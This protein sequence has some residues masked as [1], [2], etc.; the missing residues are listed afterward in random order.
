MRHLASKQRLQLPIDHRSPI[1]YIF[2]AWRGL[3]LLTRARG[4]FDEHQEF[5]GRT[6][7]LRYSRSSECR[8]SGLAFQLLFLLPTRLQLRASVLV[9]AP[10]FL[11]PRLLVS[12]GTMSAARVPNADIAANHAAKPD[13]CSPAANPRSRQSASWSRRLVHDFAI[14]QNGQ[15]GAD[16]FDYAYHSN[17]VPRLDQVTEIIG[18][19]LRLHPIAQP[20]L[21]IR[22]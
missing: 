16:G 3:T 14:A 5:G 10:L 11:R 1:Q 2:P 12:S 13:Q 15:A 21:F 20:G 6:G 17:L 8:S 7:T 22:F 9:L 18:G 19:K 4:G